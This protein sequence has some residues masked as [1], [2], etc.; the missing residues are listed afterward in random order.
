LGKKYVTAATPVRGF[1]RSKEQ[2]P[3]PRGAL[4]NKERQTRRSQSGDKEM[5]PLATSI[6]LAILFIDV[7]GS[8]SPVPC[9]DGR[10]PPAGVR[11]MLETLESKKRRVTVGALEQSNRFAL[12]V[13]TQRADRTS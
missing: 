3:T 11:R 12:I 13:G 2:A 5:K 6:F 4:T 9:T 7:V 10:E 8:I 1:V